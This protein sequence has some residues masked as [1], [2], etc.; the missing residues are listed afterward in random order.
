[1]SGS[2]RNGPV[3]GSGPK[4]RIPGKQRRG[5]ARPRLARMVTDTRPI[6]V[7]DL[8]DT[9]PIHAGT[10][11]GASRII[12]GGS[13]GTV[14]PSQN[15][16]KHAA[17]TPQDRPVDATSEPV[18]SVGGQPAGAPGRGL[19]GRS[20]R[21]E[22]DVAGRGETVVVRPEPCGTGFALSGGALP[23]MRGTSQGIRAWRPAGSWGRLCPLTCVGSCAGFAAVAD[24]L[25][26]G[27]VPGHGPGCLNALSSEPTTE[28]CRGE[29]MGERIGASGIEAGRATGET[30]SRR[31]R[32][33]R[34]GRRVVGAV[35]DRVRAV[36][37][38]VPAMSGRTLGTCEQPAAGIRR[39]SCP[40]TWVG[41]CAGVGAVAGALV[42]GVVRMHAPGCWARCRRLPDPRSPRESRPRCGRR[43][44][45]RP[46]QPERAPPWQLPVEDPS[47]MA[48]GRGVPRTIVPIFAIR[49]PGH[50]HPN[51]RLRD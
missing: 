11:F 23:S 5:L 14:R 17:N 13:P 48:A 18:D 2:A 45:R 30:R 10:D 15:A 16:G 12:G 33:Q 25:V 26:T 37:D 22:P 41:Q 36:G 40:L 28:L 29:I 6:H 31:C 27:L 44:A 42:T 50:L 32:A 3:A 49:T 35:Q 39:R 47:R 9:R 8:T 24:A 20:A 38:L 1:M 46:A 51:R 7:G 4:G 43:R 19:A 21:P 34:D